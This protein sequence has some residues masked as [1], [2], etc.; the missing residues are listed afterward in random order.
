MAD[1]EPPQ[2]EDSQASAVVPGVRERVWNHVRVMWAT[3][4]QGLF[5]GPGMLYMAL[6][7]VTCGWAT[8][9]LPTINGTHTSPETLGVYVISLLVTLFAEAL[10]TWKKG[11]E[12]RVALTIMVLSVVLGIVAMFLSSKVTSA[13]GVRDWLPFAQGALIAVLVFTLVLWLALNAV[14]PKLPNPVTTKRPSTASFDS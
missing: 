10:F 1:A 3:C 9:Y 5:S 7:V 6:V 2:A 13:Q 12:D 14:D 4:I 8:Y 11:V